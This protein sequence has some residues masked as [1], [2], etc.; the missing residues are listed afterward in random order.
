[1]MGSR[2]KSKNGRSSAFWTM[3]FHLQ[4]SKVSEMLHTDAG[5][6]RLTPYP[7]RRRLYELES[8]ESLSPSRSVPSRRVSLSLQAGPA[9]TLR[10]GRL[11][12]GFRIYNNLA[13]YTLTFFKDDQSNQLYRHG[14]DSWSPE[15]HKFITFGS[16][17]RA[18]VDKAR[19]TTHLQSPFSAIQA[20]HIGPMTG[21]S[22]G[23]RV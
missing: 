2:K 14:N 19:L 9:R 8:N 11:R 15:L 20:P 5:S 23:A 3:F 1:M 21:P 10:Q 6:V 22:K 13:T 16:R 4:A 18:E 17:G 12:S 7:R